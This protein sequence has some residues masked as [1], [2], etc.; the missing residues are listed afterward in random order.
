MIRRSKPPAYIHFGRVTSP[1][2]SLLAGASRQRRTALCFPYHG[3]DFAWIKLFPPFGKMKYAQPEKTTAR[4]YLSC[5]VVV[6]DL[7]ITGGEKKTL[8]AHQAGLN[9]VGIGGLWNWLSHGEPIDDLNLISWDSRTCTIIPDS[10]AFERPDLMR[11]VY[12]LGCELKDRGLG[13]YVAQIPGKESASLGLM[14]ISS[15][16]GNV[17]SLEI[18]H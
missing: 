7:V 15:P 18:F 12:A 13:V 16:G 8:A 10:G 4:L 5:S 6:G 14:I 11:A 17:D 1:Y 2:S 9:A 3:G